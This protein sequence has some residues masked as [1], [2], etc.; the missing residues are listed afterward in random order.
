GNGKA[1][2]A[3]KP[4]S[5]AEPQK[6]QQQGKKTEEPPQKSS[7]SSET[8]SG[9]AVVM[10]KMG[11]SITEGT[12]LRWLKKEG[13]TV[14]KDEP[15]V[16]ISTDKPTI[17]ATT[18]ARVAGNRFYSPLVRSIAKQEGISIGELDSVSGSG[19]GGRVNKNDMLNYVGARR[20][21]K[22]QMQPQPSK[23]KAKEAP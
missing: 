2:Q 18:V 9:Q 20:S 3:E 23:P 17:G 16:E 13:D 15:I 7:S 10:P 5:P 1:A 12:I 4:E 22:V 6:E 11:E 8:G 21:G 19:L 14:E